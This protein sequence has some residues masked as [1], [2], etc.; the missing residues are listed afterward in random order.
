MRGPSRISRSGDPCLTRR[1][2]LCEATLIIYVKVHQPI[3]AR[4][5]LP[6]ALLESFLIQSQN[7]GRFSRFGPDVL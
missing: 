7:A 3:L 6:A 4:H 1:Y 5:H 2:I